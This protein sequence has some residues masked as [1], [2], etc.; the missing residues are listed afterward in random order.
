MAALPPKA[1]I[2]AS[3]TGKSIFKVAAVLTDTQANTLLLLEHPHTLTL[4]RRAAQNGIIAPETILRERGVT[5]FETNRGGKVTYHGLMAW[6]IENGHE[7]SPHG[8]AVPLTVLV[9]SNP[10]LP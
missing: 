5:V 7:P 3:R 6:E 8:D 4:G 10:T 1:D 9:A 2:G